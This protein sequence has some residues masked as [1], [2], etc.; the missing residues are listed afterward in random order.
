MSARARL[1]KPLGKRG[2]AMVTAAAEAVVLIN[3]RLEIFFM[4]PPFFILF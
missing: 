4:N 1:Y 2:V 3:E